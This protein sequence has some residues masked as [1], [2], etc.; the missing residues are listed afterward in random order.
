MATQDGTGDSGPAATGDP[1]PSDGPEDTGTDTG[2]GTD[3]APGDD[4]DKGE[5]KPDTKPDPTTAK[6]L[7]D[8]RAELEKAKADNAALTKASRKHEDR[9]KANQAAAAELEQI[10]T[11]DLPEHEKALA[12]ARKAGKAEAMVEFGSKLVVAEFRAATVGRIDAEKLAV[13]LDGLN[14]ARF[15][16]DDGEAMRDDIVRYV[17]SIIPAAPPAPAKEEDPDPGRRRSGEPEN[18]IGQGAGRGA[19]PDALNSDELGKALE[20]AVGLR[21]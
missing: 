6:Q 21:R 13:L 8:M 4:G 17:D 19:Q 5:P 18:D 10:R 15:V 11:K 12:E 9:A 14:L 7:A 20:R 3:D 16:D 2:A 1:A